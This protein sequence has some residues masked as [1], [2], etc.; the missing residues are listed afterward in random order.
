MYYVRAG[1]CVI[2]RATSPLLACTPEGDF[3]PLQCLT[4]GFP[5]M[6]QCVEPS[7]GTPVPGTQVVVADPGNFPNCDNEGNFSYRTS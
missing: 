3:E 4:S 7:D 6:C 2:A 1:P 5:T